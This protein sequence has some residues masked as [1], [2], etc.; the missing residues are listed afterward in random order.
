LDT[1]KPSCFVAFFWVFSVY[2]QIEIERFGLIFAGE[3]G[4]DLH[5]VRCGGT[6]QAT[7][8]EVTQGVWKVY[9]LQAN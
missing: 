4:P 9:A 1:H 3:R 2:Q 8:D 7:N 5:E 6:P